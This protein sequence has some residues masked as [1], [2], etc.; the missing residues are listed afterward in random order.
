MLTYL[1][2]QPLSNIVPGLNNAVTTLQAS[3]ASLTAMK[4]DKDSELNGILGQ[5]AAINDMLTKVNTA[6][7]EAQ[8][9]LS[10]ATDVLGNSDSLLGNL[11]GALAAAGI[12][13]YVYGGAAGNLGSELGTQLGSGV[14]DGEGVDQ[15]VFG[16]VLVTGDGGAWSAI[17]TVLRTS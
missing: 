13:L 7:T 1:G 11:A 3:S 8:S 2:S 6:A 12:H 9:I 17:Q 16:L 4:A 10:A 15:Q 14:P 5:A